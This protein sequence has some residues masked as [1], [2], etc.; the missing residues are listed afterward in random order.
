MVNN[1][2]IVSIIKKISSISG[3]PCKKTLQ[4][5]VFLIEVKGEDLG[6]GYGIHFYGPYSA[7]LDFAVRKLNEEG[8]VGIEYSPTAHRISVVGDGHD[9]Y[10][11]T[12]IDEVV[13]EF[14]KDSPS[15]L[16]LL[17]TALFVYK[18]TGNDEGKVKPWVQKIKGS[19]YPDTQIE[20]AIE[21][22]KKVGYI[23]T[24]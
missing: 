11:S 22:L 3:S 15:D 12:I 23:K 1:E 13:E 21:R 9:G 17:T 18:R 4:K 2:A 14:A 7:D 6:C 19:K 20:E 5:M 24:A 16:E 10:N 8:R